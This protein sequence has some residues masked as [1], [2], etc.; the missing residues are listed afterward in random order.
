MEVK[1]STYAIRVLV[2]RWCDVSWKEKTTHY[3]SR[4]MYVC[5]MDDVC[6]SIATYPDHACVFCFRLLAPG[7]PTEMEP[8]RTYMAC[9]GI[10]DDPVDR[11]SPSTSLLIS[12]ATKQPRSLSHQNCTSSTP[13]Q[14]SGSPTGPS[15]PCPPSAPSPGP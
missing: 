1:G 11:V 4:Y 9:Y 7:S 10:D 3:V 5:T 15:R 8:C 2:P 13:P 12:A 6:Q 14:P